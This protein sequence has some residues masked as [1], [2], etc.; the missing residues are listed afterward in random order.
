MFFVMAGCLL[1]WFYYTPKNPY[2]QI[3]FGVFVSPGMAC[4][5]VLAGSCIADICDIDE[6][7]TGMRREG[8]YGALY[9]WLMKTGVAA[10]LFFSGFIVSWTGFD[11]DLTTQ[12]PETI[13]RLRLTFAICPVILLSVAVFLISFYPINKKKLEDIQRQLLEKKGL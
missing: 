5:W 6:L 7:A 10:V 13:L 4:I 9:T 11:R 3:L 12:T 2:F 8:I 1:S